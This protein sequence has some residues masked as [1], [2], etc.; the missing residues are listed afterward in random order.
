MNIY[1][2]N[3]DYGVRESDLRDMMEE[4][5]G[6]TSAKLIMDR[7][8]GRS[9]GFGFIEMD[10]NDEANTAIRNLNGTMHQG[11]SMVVK[12]ATPRAY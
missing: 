8:S 3:L 2:G 6:V 1:I 4:F 11:R 10:N 9:K 5:G 12:E 7:E